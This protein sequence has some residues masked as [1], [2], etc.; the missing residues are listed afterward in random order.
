MSEINISK[1]QS[2]PF[3]RYRRPQIIVQNQGNSTVILNAAEIAQKLDRPLD[4]LAKMF[5]VYRKCSVRPKD[6]T[7]VIK[8][9]FSSNNLEANLQEYTNHF[10][11]CPKCSNPETSYVVYSSKLGVHCKACGEKNRIW[12]DF[13]NKDAEKLA[14]FIITTAKRK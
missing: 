14:R 2:D 13:T 10:I 11:L 1:D 9:T 6:G 12:K 4:E 3:Y 7:I 5:Q 8:G